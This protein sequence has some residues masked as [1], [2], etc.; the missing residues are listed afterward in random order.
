MITSIKHEIYLLGKYNC[1]WI[2]FSFTSVTIQVP[3]S[4]HMK[5][6]SL[7]FFCKELNKYQ[8]QTST[9]ITHTH[10]QCSQSQIERQDIRECNS[11][12]NVLENV[13]QNQIL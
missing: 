12:S 10:T 13:W 8:W 6:E 9:T 5:K 3:V 2:Y 1:S 4:V 7:I 11:K